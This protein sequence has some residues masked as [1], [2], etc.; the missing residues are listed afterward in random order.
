MSRTLLIGAVLLAAAVVAQQPPPGPTQPQWPMQFDVAFGYTDASVGY[1][2]ASS[3]FF[4]NWPLGATK[5][6]YSS[7]P[8]TVL[9][10][11]SCQIL[12]NMNGTYLI[13]QSKCCFLWPYVFPIPPD[14]L[15][16]YV[17]SKYETGVA[18]LYGKQHDTAK[19]TGGTYSY[20]TDKTTGN[21]VRYEHGTNTTWHFGAPDKATQSAA[22]FA[23]PNGGADCQ[24]ACPASMTVGDAPFPHSDKARVMP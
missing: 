15:A 22:I 11:K 5:V 17:F 23:L 19:W 3:H 14:H 4:Y 20:N 1:N 10:H 8:P 9:K 21:Q 24:A 2:N 16:P 13:A 7:C 18:D 12:S 6:T